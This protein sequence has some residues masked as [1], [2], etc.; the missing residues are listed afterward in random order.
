MTDWITIIIRLVLAALFGGVIGYQRELTDRPAGFRTHVMVS[1][2]SSLFMLVSIYPFKDGTVDPTRIAAQVVTGIGF[3]G[4]GTIIRQGNI[5]VGLTTAASLWSVSAVGLAAGAGFYSGALVGTV[6]ILIALTIFKAIESRLIISREHRVIHLV[7]EDGLE[8]TRRIEE[9][10]KS[11][12]IE[13]ENIEHTR[14]G[15]GKISL[16]L[17]LTFPSTYSAKEVFDELTRF[18]GVTGIRWEL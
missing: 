14:M 1:V 7:V 9:F 15:D 2:G 11:K 18:N 3:L 8:Q 13:V 10:L 6:M 4:A 5:V 16:R 12:R 17:A